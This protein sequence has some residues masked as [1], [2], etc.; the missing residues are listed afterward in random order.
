M[1][2]MPPQ[3]FVGTV[4]DWSRSTRSYCV[5]CNNNKAKPS[6]QLSNIPK[7][8]LYPF[9]REKPNLGTQ[10]QLE[11]QR[12]WCLGS[13][14]DVMGSYAQTQ[15]QGRTR[16]RPACLDPDD[17]ESLAAHDLRGESACERSDWETEGGDATRRLPR[18]GGIHEC[19]TVHARIRLSPKKTQMT[20]P[21]SR[22]SR[23]G[24][25]AGCLSSGFLKIRS[26]SARIARRNGDEDARSK[27]SRN[28]K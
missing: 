23:R 6:Q 10:G 7:N 3:S 2:G 19:C 20:A 22:R 17:V 1:C 28:C 8:V 9:G 12:C 15:M 26:A 16:G 21:P 4:Q 25:E 27:L 5:P 18:F 14:K 11:R 24:G 13:V